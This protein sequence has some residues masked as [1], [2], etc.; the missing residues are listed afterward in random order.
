MLLYVPVAWLSSWGISLRTI[1]I[2]AAPFREGD[3]VL[4]NQYLHRGNW[5]G[6]GQIVLYELP[7]QTLT[8][9]ELHHGQRRWEFYG[10]RVDRVIGISL[11]TVVC[12]NGLITVNGFPFPYAPLN[13]TNLPMNW[14]FTV[15]ENHV[16]ILP[17]TTPDIGRDMPLSLL[18]DLS[19]I[20]KDR[21]YGNVY[22]RYQPLSRMGMIR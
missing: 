1:Q 17:S 14:S 15:P 13:A 8:V 4:V 5:I 16:L 22:M 18:R 6:R 20:P 12:K 9:G 7:P 3:V 2:T 10:E 21:V 11:D 19:I